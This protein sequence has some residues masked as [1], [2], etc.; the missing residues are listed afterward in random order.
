MQFNL[1]DKIAIMGRSGCG[2][3]YL[4]KKL[5]DV[6]PRKVIIDSLNEYHSE[7]EKFNDFIEFTERLKEL[8]KSPEFTLVYQFSPEQTQTDLEFNELMRVLYYLGNVLIV[9]EEV[10]TYS[11]PHYLPHWLKVAILTGRHRNVGFIFTTQRAGE[12]NKTVVSQCAHIFCGNLMDKNDI[13][14]CSS[15]FNKFSDE[16]INL[17]NREFI[18]RGPAGI[19]K[20]TNDF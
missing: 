15:L 9:I 13:N 2:K 16:L 4:C 18:Y 17:K 8:E 19:Q 14:Y 3:S 5:Q 20:I 1:S 12:L 11:N 10:Q 6:W 7:K